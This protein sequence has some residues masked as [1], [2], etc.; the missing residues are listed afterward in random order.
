ML[1]IE[2]RSASIAAQTRSHGLWADSVVAA[3]D[4]SANPNTPLTMLC[5][6]L[7]RSPLLV[8]G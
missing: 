7:M 2:A 1:A 3:T 5:F 8:I 4:A 6:I